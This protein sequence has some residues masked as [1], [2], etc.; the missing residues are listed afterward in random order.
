MQIIKALLTIT[1][2]FLK[3]LS[4]ML[5]MVAALGLLIASVAVPILWISKK[6]AENPN[7]G[8]YLLLRETS[9]KTGT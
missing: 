3:N 9:C 7:L 6:C 8:C 5:G 2:V 4:I 1:L